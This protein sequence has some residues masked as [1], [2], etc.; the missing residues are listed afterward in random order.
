MENNNGD[1][2]VFDVM[3]IVGIDCGGKFCFC[4]IGCLLGLGLYILGLCIDVFLYILVCDGNI[5]MV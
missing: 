5:Y 2:V 1:V 3:L 4:Y